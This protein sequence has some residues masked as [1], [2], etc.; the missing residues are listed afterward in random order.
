MTIGIFFICNFSDA[1]KLV[2]YY[3]HCKPNQYEKNLFLV[4]TAF[5]SSKFLLL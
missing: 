2:S 3:L 1:T 4:F 5:F